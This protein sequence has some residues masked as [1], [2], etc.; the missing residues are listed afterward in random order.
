MAVE[1]LRLVEVKKG[2]KWI[3]VRLEQIEKGDIFRMTEP[4]GKPVRMGRKRNFLALSNAF[5]DDSGR[6][7]VQCEA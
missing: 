1:L 2:S 4:D 7:T 3:I 5:Q 6:W